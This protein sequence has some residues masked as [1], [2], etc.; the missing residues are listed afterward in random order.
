MSAPHLTSALASLRSGRILRPLADA[1]AE[2][3][4]EE[5]AA[6]LPEIYGTADLECLQRIASRLGDEAGGER[7]AEVV[8]LSETRIHVIQ[9]LAKPIGS[10][11]LAV[12]PASRSVGLVLS[13]IH[14]QAAA[15]EDEP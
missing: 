13:Q 11:L 4:L 12:S 8:L 1:D 9:P 2:Q 15:L 6:T 5:L 14:A 7:L 3:Q 10:A